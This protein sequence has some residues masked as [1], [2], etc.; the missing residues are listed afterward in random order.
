[1][2][3]SSMAGTDQELMEASQSFV[4]EVTERESRIIDDPVIKNTLMK[5]FT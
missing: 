4:I 3:N 5:A 2:I 1:M